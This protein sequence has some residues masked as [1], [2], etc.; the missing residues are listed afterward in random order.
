[1]NTV[2]DEYN[3]QAE[4]LGRPVL[5][6][7]QV[8]KYSFLSDFELLHCTH[9]DITQKPWANPLVRNGMISWMKIERAKEEINCL[10]VKVR[11]LMTY[12]QDSSI[13]WQRAI[14]HLHQT[15]P[16]LATELQ[17]RHKAQSSINTLLLQQLR[18]MQL[19]QGFNRQTTPGVQAGS[20]LEGPTSETDEDSSVMDV[21]DMM[22][23]GIVADAAVEDEI[24]DQLF[25][26]DNLRPDSVPYQF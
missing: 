14:Q 11:R 15:N 20:I 9:N 16:A 6:F 2:L 13:A 12:I 17:G 25:C 23:H 5:D 4:C 8:I 18:K 24:R 10:N 7:Q 22:E 21:I 1:M 19:L 3:R 26:L